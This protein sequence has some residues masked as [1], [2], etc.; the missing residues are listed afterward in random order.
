MMISSFEAGSLLALTSFPVAAALLAIVASAGSA[1]AAEPASLFDLTATNIDGKPQALSAYKGEVVLV[2]N[3]ASACGFTPQYAGL[4]KL[5]E[6]YKGKGF[7]IL[8]FPSNDFGGQEPGTAAEIKSFCEKRFKVTFPLFDKVATKGASPSPGRGRS[9][10]PA[11]QRRPP[12]PESQL[13]AVGVTRVHGPVRM[14]PSSAMTRFCAELQVTR[15][16]PAPSM[17]LMRVTPEP[18][19]STSRPGP[20][21]IRA[22]PA[23][24]ASTRSSPRPPDAAESAAVTSN[25]SLPGPPKPTLS[26]V[27]M[28]I[29]SAPN[30]PNTTL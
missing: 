14:S 15:S 12:R 4:E 17:A 22:L 19:I 24:V 21:T 2:V 25:V 29:R 6:E 20:P 11:A 23:V 27:E 8:G 10:R 26:D 3:T 5:Y 28:V 1:G 9:T 18:P 13:P 16:P 7:T 30:P